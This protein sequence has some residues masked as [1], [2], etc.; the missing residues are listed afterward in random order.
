MI[1]LG[2]FLPFGNE[3]SLFLITLSSYVLHTSIRF[4]DTFW[5]IYITTLSIGTYRSKINFCFQVNEEKDKVV[6]KYSSAQLTCGTN[7]VS[8]RFHQGMSQCLVM[9]QGSFYRRSRGLCKLNVVSLVFD[10]GSL[11][12]PYCRTIFVTAQM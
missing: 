9:K 3:Y 2:L 11:A 5:L 12:P 7:S 1:L 10:K 4:L 6:G 8:R